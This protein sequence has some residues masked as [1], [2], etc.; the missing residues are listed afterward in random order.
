[1]G[2]RVFFVLSK[3]LGVML[4][5]T[6][7][8][9]GLGLLGALLLATRFAPLGRKLLVAAVLLL[10]ICA[11]SP[12]GNLLLYPLEQRFPPWDAGQGTPDGIVILGGSID[13]DLSV[14]HAT[15]VIRSA[16]D[17]IVAAAE[18]ARRYPD[19]RIVF[20]GGSA[21]LISNDA[22]EADYAAEVFESLGIAKSRL[23]ME[24]LSRN[25]AEN[26]LF[27]KT[28]AAPKAGERWLLVTSAFHMPRAIGLFRK[29]GFAVEPYP[30]DW[31]VGGRDDLLSFTNYAGD[32]LGRTDTA[33]R[34]WIGLVAYR[35][36]GRIGELLPGPAKD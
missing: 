26:A 23:A 25:T 18:L 19:A 20:S 2:L 11:F 13:P 14:A 36:T 33:V 16:A 10:A 9:I 6:N 30:V 29:A 5:P 35:L 17:R 24:R 8:L 21:N 4:L 32:G 34:E 27:S 12:L 31:R 1:V 28:I 7:F 22:K 15:T 3:T